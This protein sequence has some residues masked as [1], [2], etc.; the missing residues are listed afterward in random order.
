MIGIGVPFPA[1]EFPGIDVATTGTRAPVPVVAVDAVF[2]ERVRRTMMGDLLW[3]ADLL[4][5]LGDE[6]DEGGAV[7]GL[8]A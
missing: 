5:D 8:Q 3:L 1:S 2:V 6:D 7:D 4:A